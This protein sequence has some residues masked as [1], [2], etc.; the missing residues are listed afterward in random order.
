MA[1]LTTKVCDI[2]FK[3][4]VLPASGPNV[5]SPEKILQAS[6][7]GVGGI[8]TKTVSVKAA[9][10]PRPTIL[11]ASNGGLLNCETWSESV[12]EDFFEVYRNVKSKGLPLICSIGYSAEE[13][14]YLGK[15][16]EKEVKPDAFEFSTHYSG[17]S[18]LSLLEVAKALKDSVSV[19]IFMKV[20]PSMHDF[21]FII[22]SVS[23]IVDGF[24]A[25][26]SLGPCLDFNVENPVPGLGSDWGLGWLSGAPILPL[27]LGAVCRIAMIQNKPVIGVGGI[28]SGVDAIKHIMAGASA[29]GIC[30]AAI[31]Q[32]DGIY[33]KVAGEMSEWLDKHEKKL[34]DIKGVFIRNARLQ[35]C[36]KAFVKA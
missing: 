28:S 27:A 29:V 7:S 5:G 16:L 8:V 3:N 14:S 23:E 21:E 20:S 25:I 11:K 32:G 19:S 26:N 34:E 31:T 24:I 22:K 10:D 4:P 1:N 33:G 36:R 12:V 6:E 9:K 17:K 35:N 13:V 18:L 15:L 30:S 2:V